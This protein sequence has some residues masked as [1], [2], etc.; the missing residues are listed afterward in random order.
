MYL[1][2]WKTWKTETW[3]YYLTKKPSKTRYL[4]WSLQKQHQQFLQGS[5]RSWAGETIRWKYI[6]LSIW[7]FEV[8]N[9]HRL[10]VTG[11]LHPG[12]KTS[13][14]SDTAHM[15]TS[16]NCSGAFI[17]TLSNTAAVFRFA[18]CLWVLAPTFL[19]LHPHENEH[20]FC[21]GME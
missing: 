6:H 3:S 18:K 19:L 10:H 16:A 12:S 5:T 21:W 4:D 9:D 17:L 15:E 2:E 13:H 20:S 8:F 11:K 7:G 14:E 1:S